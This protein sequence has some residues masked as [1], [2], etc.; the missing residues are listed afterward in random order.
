MENK[1]KVPN[2]ANLYSYTYENKLYYLY[3]LKIHKIIDTE[4]VKDDKGRRFTDKDKLIVFAN[5]E[6]TRLKKEA[7]YK[8]KGIPLSPATYSNKTLDEFWVECKNDAYLA[9]KASATITKYESVY[10]NHIKDYQVRKPFTNELISFGDMVFSE[11]T[12][13]D[14]EGLMNTKKISTFTIKGKTKTYS[15]SYVVSIYKFFL[16][17]I[18]YINKKKLLP[19][20]ILNNFAKLKYTKNKIQKEEEEN[21]KIRALNEEQIQQIESL[22][23]DTPMY[24]PFL[25]GL[26]AGCRPAEAAALRFS[27]VDFVNKKLRINKQIIKEKNHYIFKKPKTFGRT[28][29]VPD[30]FLEAVKKRMDEI[31]E[32]KKK[33]PLFNSQTIVFDNINSKENLAINDFLAIDNEGKYC[34][35]ESYFKKYSKIIRETI[36]PDEYGVEEFAFYTFRKTHLTKMARTNIPIAVLKNRSG[37]SKIDTLFRYYY[38]NSDEEDQFNQE[39]LDKAFKF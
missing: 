17:I 13:S 39:A 10:K 8:M 24:L 38:A 30:Y 26:L 11:I 19:E 33:N 7:E 27:D 29:I 22:L 14:I 1:K 28:V 6:K 12:I 18:G 5:Q 4:I 2:Y 15:E 20:E 25:A 37:H 16:L 36:C 34:Y 32:I 3:R 9:Q 31:E 35:I 21:K 23:K